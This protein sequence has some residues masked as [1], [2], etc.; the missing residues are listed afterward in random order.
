MQFEL[1][2]E[3]WRAVRPL[4]GMRLWSGEDEAWAVAQDLVELADRGGRLRNLFDAIQS[5]R[6]E[7][8]FS[9][10]WSRAKE[11]FERKLYRKRSRHRVSFV[12]LPDTIPVLGPDSEVD[13]NRA[14]DTLFS[15]VSPKEGQVVVCLRSGNTTL[16]D[17]AKDLGYANHSAISKQLA[18]TAENLLGASGHL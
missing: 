10:R 13:A 17:I 12:E 8:D 7:D 1:L 2:P 16:S 14:W 15:V 9:P 4:K 11:D 6:V 3:G 5:A 18:L